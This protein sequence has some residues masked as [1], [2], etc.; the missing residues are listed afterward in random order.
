MFSLFI[1]IRKINH[2]CTINIDYQKNFWA[3]IISDSVLRLTV[4]TLA[5]TECDI[6]TLYFDTNQQARSAL[7]LTVCESAKSF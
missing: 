5:V 1:K 6:P 3:F 7:V 4:S 2:D